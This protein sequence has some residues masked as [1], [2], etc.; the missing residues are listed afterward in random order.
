MPLKNSISASL[1]RLRFGAR[2]DPVR[3]WLALLTVFAIAF[4]GIIV[5]NVRAFGTVAEGGSIGTPTAGTSA[6]AG[7]TSIENI[8]AVFKSRATE[9]AKYDTGVYHYADPSQ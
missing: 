9:K 6:I 8:R 3:D 7:Q 4:A 5:W 2:I 1:K